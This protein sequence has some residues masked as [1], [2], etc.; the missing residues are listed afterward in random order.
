[1]KISLLSFARKGGLLIF[2]ST[3]F[4]GPVKATN[5][6]CTFLLKQA[7]NSPAKLS[8]LNVSAQKCPLIADLVFWIRARKDPG[9]VSF[10][11]AVHFLNRH[12]DWPQVKLIQAAGEKKLAPSV[13]QD[14][15]LTF[16]GKNAPR[17][18]QGRV[19]YTQALLR[20]KQD[21][22]AQQLIRETW[23]E[24]SLTTTEQ[25]QFLERF[26]ENLTQ[27]DHEARLTY[28]LWGKNIEQAQQ[29]IPRVSE[30]LQRQ[31]RVWIAF[32]QNNPSVMTQYAAL[33]ASLQQHEGLYL[34]YIGYL[35]KE[36]NFDEAIKRLLAFEGPITQPV[37]W[38]QER[39]YLAREMLQINKYEEAYQL[40][41]NHGLTKA[42][43]FAE[44]EWFSGWLSLSFLKNPEQAKTHFYRFQEVVKTPIS[45]A[46]AGYWLGRT[47][48]V[49]DD[50]EQA[51]EFYKKAALYKTT[52]YGQLASHKIGQTPFP[53]FHDSPLVDAKSRHLFEKK[54][55]VQVV[56]LL[57]Q[58]GTSGQH[59]VRKFLEALAAKTSTSSE[60][61][62][63]IALAA[64]T[65]SCAAP[66][67]SRNMPDTSGV[68]LKA[69]YP[70]LPTPFRSKS[71]EE[72]LVM[73][74]I[75]HETRFNTQ[76]VGDAGE[77]GLMQIMPQTAAIEAKALGIP[78]QEKRLFEPQYNMRL[79]V[80]HLDSDLSKHSDS[81]LLTIAAYNAGG[82]R[83]A[84]W[85]AEMGDPH[86]GKFD[87]VDW[88]E[89]VPYPSVRD[90]I[91]YVLA[92]MTAYRSR[93]G[94]KERHLAHDLR[95][96]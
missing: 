47:Y 89:R 30:S 25:Q 76:A 49:L 92:A 3:L 58:T 35:K 17:T 1:M 54:E 51:Q 84:R 77:K 64:Q 21:Q 83:V 10:E 95:G 37:E 11:Q 90:Y 85:I 26:S 28:L 70:V 65:H 61:Q 18:F 59:Y 79:G 50:K 6:T 82:T 57:A 75:H 24:T 41:Q 4:M 60:K 45:L 8:H 52:F 36:K 63:T 69:V 56:R 91:Q 67:I 16:F 19:Y 86:Q 33:P 44:A 13:P 7:V 5:E 29:M 72:A 71:V 74:I 20:A 55:L 88:I 9:S 96:K 68:V 15:I 80:S 73:A 53:T 94:K 14:L 42:K 34:A 32:L 27:K 48:E 23:V 38:W 40:L 87:V 43:E 22:K 12:P 2:A 62:L 46:R 31:A 66:E 78:Y 39:N 81:Y 93:L